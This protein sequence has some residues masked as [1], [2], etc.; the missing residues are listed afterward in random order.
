[1]L[2]PRPIMVIAAFVVVSVQVSRGQTK[3]VTISVKDPRPIAAAALQIE[4]LSKVPI[5]YEDP[6][7]RNSADLQDVTDEVLSSAQKDKIG[8]AVRVI[9]A[10]G[11]ELTQT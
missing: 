5:N 4:Q 7:L 11:G 6:F 10:R 1:M 9:G 2:N 3:D 8:S